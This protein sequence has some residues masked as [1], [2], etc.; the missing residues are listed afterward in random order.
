MEIKNATVTLSG[1]TLSQPISVTTGNSG[2]YQFPAVATGQTYLVTV[3]A[4][5][6]TFSNPTQVIYLT[7]N[8]TDANFTGN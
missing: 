4:N 7:G 2:A 8:V 1:G 5:G 6:Y 3:T